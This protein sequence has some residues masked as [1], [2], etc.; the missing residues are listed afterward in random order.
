MRI[1]TCAFIG[2]VMNHGRPPDRGITIN[3]G[4]WWGRGGSVEGEGAGGVGWVGAGGGV[5]DDD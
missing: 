4:S 2:L 1:E 3:M 5:E